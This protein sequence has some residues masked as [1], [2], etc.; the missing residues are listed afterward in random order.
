MKFTPDTLSLL[1]NFSTINASILIEPGNIIS[2]AAQ[3][4]TV[5]AVAE[6]PEVFDQQ[7]AV[8]NLPEF[9]NVFSMFH[10]PVLDL[11]DGRQ[12]AIRE[13]K[14]VVRYTFA[15]PSLITKAPKKI[16]DVAPVTAFEL[17]ANQ[18]QALMKAA[19]VM[20]LPDLV[21]RGDGSHLHI[22]AAD[23]KSSSTNSYNIEVGQ[24]DANFKAIFKLENYKQVIRDYRV[25]VTNRFTKF[26]SID[27]RA[28]FK[29][30]YWIAVQ[31]ESK[32]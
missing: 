17:K 3:S 22:G 27:D 8:H 19:Q 12:A 26:E 25:T 20:G 11:N 21:I 6:V 32:F 18:L 1:K 2:T 24:T 7:L 15:E 9:L 28:A 31:Q 14:V 29:V 4:K 10:D 13:G 23:T 30:T 16:Q 5:F